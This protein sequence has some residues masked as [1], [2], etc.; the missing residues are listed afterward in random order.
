MCTKGSF[1]EIDSEGEELPDS[2]K[3]LR[4]QALRGGMAVKVWCP[5]HRRVLVLQPQF[6]PIAACRSSAEIEGEANVCVCVCVRVC[7][8]RAAVSKGREN[9]SIGFCGKKEN[10]F[11]KERKVVGGSTCGSALTVK[12][13]CFTVWLSLEGCSCWGLGVD[14]WV[15][16]VKDFCQ[17]R[18]TKKPMGQGNLEYRQECYKI[19]E[20]EDLLDEVGSE[21]RRRSV[22]LG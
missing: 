16:Q 13:I 8:L 20:P 1:P 9:L 3:V 18:E 7:G 17:T 15:H 10:E 11:A 21:D 5:D 2:A 22:H 19:A 12:Q 14:S 4:R 6:C